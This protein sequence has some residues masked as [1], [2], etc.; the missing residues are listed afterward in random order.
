MAIVI[1]T[2][3]GERMAVTGLAGGAMIICD[4]DDAMNEMTTKPMERR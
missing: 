4:A 2:P 1:D 3:S